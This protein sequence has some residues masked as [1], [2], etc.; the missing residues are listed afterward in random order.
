MIYN[1]LKDAKSV[2][3]VRQILTDELNVVKKPLTSLND[4]VASI[5]NDF[6][7]LMKSDKRQFKYIINRIARDVE[8]MARKNGEDSLSANSRAFL[9]N[10][11]AS[12]NELDIKRTVEKLVIANIKYLND[13]L[14]VKTGT[15]S[16]EEI[17]VE[18]GNVNMENSPV[19]STGN[20][21]GLVP[22]NIGHTAGWDENDQ[23]EGD[24]NPST[25]ALEDAKDKAE[26]QKFS[27]D[28]HF[29]QTSF[30]QGNSSEQV[31]APGFGVGAY[32]D[33]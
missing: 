19:K 31:S 26:Q 12:A 2:E 11:A 18:G 17:Q 28:E 6:I 25:A 1:R 7:M 3:Q 20:R 23:E 9:R 16:E 15:F 10:L 33:M 5:S 4:L 21:T 29:T 22:S 8:V 27:I 24:A 32:L 30:A 14:D 13:L